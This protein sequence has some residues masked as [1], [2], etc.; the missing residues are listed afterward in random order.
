MTLPVRF[1]R[2][3]PQP[4]RGYNGIRLSSESSQ[5]RCSGFSSASL[6]MHPYVRCEEAE[7][8][9]YVAVVVLPWATARGRCLRTPVPG[10]GLL[11]HNFRTANVRGCANRGPSIWLDEP[12]HRQD[13]FMSVVTAGAPTARWASMWVNS[14]PLLSLL[15]MPLETPRTSTS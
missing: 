1:A 9:S 10:A 11:A 2:R 12:L 13:A 14:L 6:T 5:V 3:P 7:G 8:S 15:Q 4:P